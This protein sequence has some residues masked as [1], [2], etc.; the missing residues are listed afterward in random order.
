MVKGLRFYGWLAVLILVIFVTVSEDVNAEDTGETLYAVEGNAL[1]WVLDGFPDDS[2]STE[3]IS[4]RLVRKTEGIDPLDFGLSPLVDDQGNEF[5]RELVVV[6]TPYDSAWQTWDFTYAQNRLLASKD[7]FAEVELGIHYRFPVRAG[8]YRGR[9]FSKHGDDIPL[10]IVVGHYTEVSA[11]PQEVALVVSSGPGLYE[12]KNP[13]KVAICANHG[14]WVLK[15]TSTG[16]LYQDDQDLLVEPIELFVVQEQLVALNDMPLV[17]G[18]SFGWGAELDLIIQAK[19]GWEHP[20]GSYQGK[21]L[22]DVF[23]NE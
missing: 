17:F 10:T 19:V 1:R 22:I 11:T 12:V 21:I 4:I 14:D 13:V 9:L 3:V 8:T 18:T 5:P 16:L 7:G 20:A 2:R 15:L 23:V 6:R